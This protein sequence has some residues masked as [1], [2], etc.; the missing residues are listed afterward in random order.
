MTPIGVQSA[1]QA[2]SAVNQKVFNHVAYDCSVSHGL[3]KHFYGPEAMRPTPNTFST[4][5]GFNRSMHSYES[6]HPFHRASRVPE[7]MDFRSTG[8]PFYGKGGD[9]GRV[10]SLSQYS[11]L[12]PYSVQ[13]LSSASSENGDLCMS[14][15]FSVSS[16]SLASKEPMGQEPTSREE[17]VM[18]FPRGYLPSYG[19]LFDRF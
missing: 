17:D 8:N 1:V 15:A 11:D 12:G 3:K 5:T 18:S 13:S 10:H 16:S 14:H 9:S 6:K 19:L 4:F 7:A 2:V